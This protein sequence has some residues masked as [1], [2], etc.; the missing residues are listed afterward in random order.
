MA[1]A[2][3]YYMRNV[4]HNHPDARCHTI[5]QHTVG[6]MDRDSIVLIDETALADA[7]AHWEATQLDIFMMASLNAVERTENQWH[8]L[9]ES[10]GLK[11]KCCYT[12]TDLLKDGVIVAVKAWNRVFRGAFQ[13][14]SNR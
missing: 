13:T 9:L 3:F 10:V 8:V 11:V 6:A 12:Y 1:G 7:G 5:L 4:L 14:P 2:R